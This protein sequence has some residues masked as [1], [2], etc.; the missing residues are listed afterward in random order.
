MV[1]KFHGSLE[2]TKVHAATAKMYAK[3]T[4]KAAHI[5]PCHPVGNLLTWQRGKEN[6]PMK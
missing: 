4:M 1:I 2:V 3:D 6:V 5:K